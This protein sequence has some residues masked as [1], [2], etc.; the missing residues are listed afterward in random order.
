MQAPKLWVYS[1]IEEKN[2][3]EALIVTPLTPEERVIAVLELMDIYA[4]LNK[5]NPR[6]DEEDGIEW[7]R[8]TITRQRDGE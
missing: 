4:E 1:S 8:L 5:N 7:I 3:I 2:A 6:Q